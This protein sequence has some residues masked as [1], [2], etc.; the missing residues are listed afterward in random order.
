M[1]LIIKDMKSLNAITEA[2]ILNGYIVKIETVF[3]V[4]SESSIDYFKIEIQD[5]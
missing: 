5:D 1:E 3:K 4:F 2:L